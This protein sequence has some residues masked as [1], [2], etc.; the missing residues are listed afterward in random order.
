MLANCVDVGK[1]VS[2]GQC[3]FSRFLKSYVCVYQSFFSDR[4]NSCIFISN[5]LWNC[6]AKAT[7]HY[8]M[9]TDRCRSIV[10]TPV[11]KC[12]TL[13]GKKDEVLERECRE[14]NGPK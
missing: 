14:Q 9:M 2:K 11:Q 8:F 4:D 5:R 7:Y 1:G 13:M 6:H 3:C 10:C 12:Y